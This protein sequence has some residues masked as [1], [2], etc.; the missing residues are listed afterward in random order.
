MQLLMILVTL[1]VLFA[2]VV[3]IASTMGANVLERREELGLMMAIGATRGE[4][5]MFYKAEALL[6][7]LTGG[8]TGFVFGYI[9]AQAISRGAFESFISMP[10]SLPLLSLAAGVLIS[11]S[12]SHFPVRDAI[13]EKPALI[14]RGE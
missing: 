2:A 12:A 5:G 9:S 13:R 8:M 1:V 11:L 10:L 4:I 14:L 3:S 7:G 6:I